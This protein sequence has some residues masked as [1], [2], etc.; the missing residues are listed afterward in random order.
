[1]NIK[2]SFNPNKADS[3]IDWWWTFGFRCLGTLLFV[4]AFYQ[5]AKS[6]VVDGAE[7]VAIGPTRWAFIAVGFVLAFGGKFFGE[8]AGS[9]GNRLSKK[10]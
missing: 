3:K 7:I 10:E 1:M 8:W 5:P 4:L 9:I 2:D 6:M